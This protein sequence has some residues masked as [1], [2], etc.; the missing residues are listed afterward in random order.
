M[1]IEIRNHRLDEV[2]AYEQ[3][4]LDGEESMEFEVH[5]D[6]R[7]CEYTLNWVRGVLPE[8]C[9]TKGSRKDVQRDVYEEMAG[10]AGR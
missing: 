2:L 7:E 3:G 9:P 1:I 5:G 8:M 4:F 10:W 6:C